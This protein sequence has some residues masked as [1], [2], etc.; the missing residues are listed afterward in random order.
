MYFSSNSYNKIQ[1]LCFRN[2]KYR[3]QRTEFIINKTL[4]RL[5]CSKFIKSRIQ[6]IFNRIKIN[7]YI[8]IR[9]YLST[10]N[11]NIDDINNSVY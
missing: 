10:N 2:N 7:L 5:I 6:Q 8:N 11:I 4:K 3:Y 1:I 9:Q